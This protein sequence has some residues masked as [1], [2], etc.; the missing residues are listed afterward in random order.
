MSTLTPWHEFGRSN[1]IQSVEKRFLFADP[2]PPVALGWI[3][4]LMSA[5]LADA[6]QIKKFNII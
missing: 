6:E 4:S 3:S 2:L 1:R 5:L